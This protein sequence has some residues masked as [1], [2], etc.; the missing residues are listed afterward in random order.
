[1]ITDDHYSDIK[2]WL[3]V[4]NTNKK[5]SKIFYAEGDDEFMADGKLF[6]M[7]PS[8]YCKYATF[9]EFY[10][11]IN[12]K[13]K[14]ILF[15][16]WNIEN[17]DELRRSTIESGVLNWEKMEFSV[18]TFITTNISKLSYTSGALKNHFPMNGSVTTHTTYPQQQPYSY[19]PYVPPVSIYNDG[20]YKEREVIREKFT[21]L[22]KQNKTGLAV[23]LL[24][25]A[26]TKMCENKKFSGLDLFLTALPTEY[27]NI[28]A[29]FSVLKVTCGADHILRDRRG[30]F[31][32]VK[33]RLSKTGKLNKMLDKLNEVEPG[34]EYV[35]ITK[36]SNEP[37]EIKANAAN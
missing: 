31:E 20:D 5:R 10:L 37:T 3:K 34:K 27:M 19:K 29:M 21:A 2:N 35:G 22:V 36:Y 16:A 17:F 30:F 26:I 25:S 9:D 18:L 33:S 8:E 12:V 6:K 23:E 15:Q 13:T 7:I 11:H 32:K 1:M 24:E 28:P 4:I 14:E